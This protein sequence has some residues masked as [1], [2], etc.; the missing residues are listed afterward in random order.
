MFTAVKLTHCSKYWKVV[1]NYAVLTGIDVNS[2]QCFVLPSLIHV[3]SIN[4]QIKHRALTCKLINQEI[5]IDYEKNSLSFRENQPT[6]YQMLKSL[7]TFK[8]KPCKLTMSIQ[9]LK[10]IEQFCHDEVALN[11]YH[12]N[13]VISDEDIKEEIRYLQ[14]LN[15][16][17]NYHVNSK[18]IKPSLFNA[19]ERRMQINYLHAIMAFK[20]KN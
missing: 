2:I 9:E 3:S 20:Q 7:E 10:E 14:M 6:C 13:N 18:Y 19:T 1:T 15:S 5:I 11:Y 17:Y 12:F 16:Y 8:Y 4:E